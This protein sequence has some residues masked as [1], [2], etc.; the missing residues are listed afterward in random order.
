MVARRFTIN[1]EKWAKMA[2]LRMEAFARQFTQ[3]MVKEVVQATPVDTG[4]LRGSW[5][6]RVGDPGEGPA[7]RL[8]PTGAQSVAMAQ[9]TVGSA[10]LG[11]IFYVLN[12]AAYAAHLEFGTE[13]KITGEKDGRVYVKSWSM[14][15]RAY[16][17][18]T[19]ARSREVALSTAAYIKNLTEGA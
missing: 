13:H 12:N 8:D 10:P 2:G 15:P 4:F 16:V 9:L 18:G 17:R 6:V 11:G 1:I 14:A 3:Q 19:L 7:G 5:Y